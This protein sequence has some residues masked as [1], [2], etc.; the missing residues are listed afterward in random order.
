NY[1]DQPLNATIDM[2]RIGLD[3]TAAYRMRELWSGVDSEAAA[4][5]QVTVPAADVALF[6]IEKK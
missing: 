4:T 2:Q 3:A 6:R 5:F 1:T